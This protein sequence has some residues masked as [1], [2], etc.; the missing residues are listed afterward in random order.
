MKIPRPSPRNFSRKGWGALA[1]LL[2]IGTAVLL[3]HEGHAPLPTRGAQADPEKGTLFLTADARS[4]VDV[5]T[6]VVETRAVQEKVL[7]YATLAAPWRNHGYVTARLPGRVT[8]VSVAPGRSV[9]AGEVLAEV[10]SLDLDTLQLEL[11]GAQ[12]DIALSEK[13]VTELRKSAGQGVVSGQVVLDAESTLA[14][15]KNAIEVARA[16]WL[17]LGLPRD[18]LDELFKT[19]NSIVGLTLPVRAP[20]SGVVIHAEVTAG[21]VIDTSEHLAEVMDLSTVWVRIDIL[22]KD[23][24]RVRVGQ[25]VELHLVAHPGEVFRTEIRAKSLYLNPVTNVAAVWAELAN[26][27]SVEPRFQP[28]MAGQAFVVVSDG[29]ARSSVPS[30]AV[31]RE[32]A[33]RFVLVEEANG[34]GS[35]EYRKKAVVAGRESGGWVEILGGQIFPGDRVVTRGGHELAPFFAPTVLKL[36]PEAELTI[37]LKVEPAGRKVLDNVLTLEGAVEVPTAKRGFA[38]SQLA[39][40][41]Q[42]IRVDRGQEVKPGDVV[43]EVYSP[44]L[45]TMQQELL[46]TSLEAALTDTTL[47]SLKNIPGA[48]ARRLWELESQLNGLR[49]RGEGLKRKLLTAGLT[50]DHI[51]GLLERNEMISAVPVRSPIAGVVVNFDKVLGQAVAAHE[52]LFEVHDL[53][54]PWVRGFASERDL[55]SVSLGQ[56]VR[57]RLVADP[58]FVGTGK[59]VRSSRTVGADTRSLAVWVELDR[60][61]PGGLL[62]NQLATVSVVRGSRPSA[63]AVPKSAVVHDGSATFVFVRKPDGTFDR[64][65]V[66]LGPA[67]DR[68]ITVIRGLADGEPVAVAGAGELMTAHASLR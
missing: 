10:E 16:K 60:A 42:T 4:A 66:E 43:A 57:M 45:L 50:A 58:E 17:A 39:G 7:A 3:A 30:A 6:G 21:K 25:A 55:G 47:K 33:E 5:D 56:P 26:P 64:R 59:V 13:L 35:S 29:K 44:E 51:V 14:Q 53:S 41:I 65:V 36:S 52:P 20:V 19:R 31:L 15:H 1:A 38:A 48:A 12:N 11:L 61:L 27:A 68:F 62:N 22:E 46:K 24:H 40:T 63:V 28:G 2:T 67:D 23:L 34:A 8:H 9:K 49:T 37:G 18:S 54:A 32:G